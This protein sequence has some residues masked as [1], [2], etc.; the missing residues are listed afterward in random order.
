[1]DKKYIDPLE[2]EQF[3][4]HKVVYIYRQ[5]HFHSINFDNV[6]SILFNRKEVKQL[7]ESSNHL[8]LL[9]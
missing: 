4:F 9:P 2:P 8:S 3:H 1:M 5:T 7:K 6:L